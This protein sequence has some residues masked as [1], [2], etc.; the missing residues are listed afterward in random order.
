MKTGVVLLE[1]VKV[2]A[3]T[4][5]DSRQRLL[6]V[7]KRIRILDCRESRLLEKGKTFRQRV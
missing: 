3:E 1:N 7:G 4:S 6:L 5:N 2:T